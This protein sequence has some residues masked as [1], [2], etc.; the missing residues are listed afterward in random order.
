MR[1]FGFVITSIA[2]MALVLASGTGHA[3]TPVYEGGTVEGDGKITGTVTW[4]GERPTLEPFEI[5]KNPEV[6]DTH[7][8]GKRPS[9]RL[10][11]SDSGGVANAVVYL[12]GITAGKPQSTAAAT[13][14]QVG[15]HYEP[16]VQVVPKRAEL[17][18]KSKDAILHNIHMYGAASYNIPFPDKNELVKRMRKAGVVRVQCDAGH[19]W[20][21]AFI[22]VTDHPY[23]AVT[24]ESGAF[25]L[26][27]V[28]PGKYTIK[29]WH[30]HWDVTGKTEKDGVVSGYEF[31]D[32]IEQTKSVEVS[33]GGVTVDFTLSL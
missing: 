5:N 21:S 11:V 28:P 24:D 16:H 12:E 6:C 30:A 14:D 18:L 13:L 33:S 4:T 23:Y 29:M 1:G 15:C 27:D 26:D 7:G 2:V 20:M 25:E 22:H 8:D 19:G 9:H 31:P 17:T 32:P 10:M 3:Q